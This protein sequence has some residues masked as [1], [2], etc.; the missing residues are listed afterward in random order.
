MHVFTAMLL[1]AALAMVASADDHKW[2]EFPRN[3]V[4]SRDGGVLATYNT[5]AT[6]ED[7]KAQCLADWPATTGI[8]HRGYD[9]S[10]A[11]QSDV[12]SY[13]PV[14]SKAV[15][16]KATALLK[17]DD[18]AFCVEG[19]LDGADDVSDFEG[20]Y[21]DCG[22]G[23]GDVANAFVWVRGP[24]GDMLSPTGEPGVCY[25]KQLPDDFDTSSVAAAPGSGKI[26]CQM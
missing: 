13:N 6:V 19:D 23:C 21:D 4:A 15:D 26:F 14:W 5:T 25:C 18:Y 16:L 10:C 3:A 9:K 24:L 2:L 17:Y 1:P 11:C 12:F 22:V 7:C 20:N 8:S